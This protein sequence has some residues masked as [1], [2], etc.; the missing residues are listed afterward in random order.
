MKKTI[1]EIIDGLV[2]DIKIKDKKILKVFEKNND[3]AS[4]NYVS[5]TTGVVSGIKYSQYFYKKLSNKISFTILKE[6]GEFVNR[7]D[8]IAVITGPVNEILKGEK[9]GLEFVRVSSGISSIT[10]KYVQELVGTNANIIFSEYAIPGLE[11]LCINAFRLGGG[12]FFEENKKY[13]LTRNIRT[14]FDSYDEA[15]EKIKEIDSSLK[16]V[17]E[18]E[19][20]DD[21]IEA[22]H[23]K[24]D[25]IRVCSNKIDFLKKISTLNSTN[26]PLEALGNYELKAIRGLTK[27][28]YKNLLIPALTDEANA[29]SIDL[30]F[31]K[32]V[33][34]GK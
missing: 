2:S 22:M 24:C 12:T 7:G 10:K 29:L 20:E 27:L 23:S 25:S 21:F 9:I 15:I 6:D 17:I 14:R 28:G 32:R 11:E 16:A 31:Y 26:K 13:V 5:R 30:C 19:N 33:K 8:V 18:I 3:V 34:K 1:E 4:C